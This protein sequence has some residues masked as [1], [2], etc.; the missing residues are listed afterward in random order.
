MQVNKTREKI[1]PIKI[2]QC[3]L[4]KFFPN[5]CE[6]TEHG[7]LAQLKERKAISC[8]KGYTIRMKRNGTIYIKEIHCLTCGSRLVK[9]GYNDRIAILDN[10]LGKHE[11]RIQRKR[12]CRCGEIKPDYSKIAPKHG[13]YHE[14]YKRR[15]R[16][17]YMEGLMSSQIQRVF[18]I[19]FN[20]KIALTTIVNWIGQVAEL[21]RET[22]K[23][24]PVPSSGYWGYD[25]IH[26]RIN[27]ERMYAMD[28]VDINTRFVPVAKISRNMGR[29][30]GREVLMEGRRG[31]NL[32]INGLV[33]DCTANLGGLFRT[34]SFKHIKQQNCLTHVK[35]IVS[36]HVKAFAGLSKQSTKPVPEKWRWLLKR[37]Y[38]LIDSK[39]ETDA[40]IKVEIL[41]GTVERLKGKKIKELHAA[42]KQLESWLPKIIAHQRNPFI[43]TTNNLLEG[44][45]K[46]YTYYP[47]FKRSMMTPEG[48]QRVLDYRVFRHNFGRFPEFIIDLNENY[49]RYRLLVRET[50]NHSSIRGHRMYFKHERIK[51]DQWYGNY[52]QLWNQYFAII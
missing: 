38:S 17:H 42:L 39:D 30:E 45:H 10:G 44:F 36:K 24:T 20:M 16:Q 21:L 9:N 32:W 31:K 19:D 18:K 2:E 33:K 43:P 41:R 47:S 25:E 13:N 1:A 22:L 5:L 4:N 8:D 29:N 3:T 37:F 15:A 49:K 6:S 50:H 14:N 23:E 46:K 7:L 35:W 27:K 40:Y 28:T 26:L 12:C 11:F 48:A 51:F 52:Q 34:R